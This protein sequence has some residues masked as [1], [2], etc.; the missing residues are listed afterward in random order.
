MSSYPSEEERAALW[1]QQV[2]DRIAFRQRLWESLRAPPGPRQ[3]VLDAW[4]PVL[5]W[6]AERGITTDPEDDP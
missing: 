3:A 5:A 1:R 2:R 4:A 6:Q